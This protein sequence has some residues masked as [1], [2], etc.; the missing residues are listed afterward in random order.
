M[1]GVSLAR[2]PLQGITRKE[3]LTRSLCDESLTRRGEESLGKRRGVSCE[4]SLARSLSQGFSR[5]E[6]LVRSLSRGVSREESLVRSHLQGVSHKESLAS[7]LQG[8]SREEST[9]GRTVADHI[10]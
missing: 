1:R 8:V 5:E 10:C 2:I 4:E 6:S 3:S 7:L 9:G